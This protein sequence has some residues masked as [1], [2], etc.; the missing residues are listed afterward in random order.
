MRELSTLC[1]V[2]A[3]VVV[4]SPGGTQPEVWPSVPEATNILQNV[5]DLPDS[6][7][8][9]KVLDQ[10]G[11]LKQNV[12]KATE[13]LRKLERDNREREVN[14][15]IQDFIV[16]HRKSL[17]DL[18]LDMARDLEWVVDQR[19][20]AVSSRI[21]QLRSKPALA[22]RPQQ[23]APVTALGAMP[24]AQVP[25]VAPPAAA[26]LGT[27]APMG[28]DGEPRQGS[29]LMEMLKACDVDGSGVLMSEAGVARPPKPFQ[30]M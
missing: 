16:G 5:K 11:L 27:D 24:L 28:L 14:I 13:K 12:A 6:D 17:D 15:I 26:D 19:L 22:P 7:K 10:E 8:C 23:D 25:M 18:S 9:K 1:D 4:Y 30:P 2:P 3:C 20:Q 29:F 21:E